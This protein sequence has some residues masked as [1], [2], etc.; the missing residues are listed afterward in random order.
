VKVHLLDGTYELFRAYYGGPPARNEAGVE[1]G[2]A[3]TLLRS[4]ATL[5]DDPGVTHVACAFD[6]VIESF[7]NDLFDGYKTGDGIEPELFAQFELAERV[8]EALGIV[9]WPM[10][11]FEADDAIAAAAE[12]S[13]QDPRVEQILLCSPD[14][15][16]AQCVRGDR[17]VCLDRMRKT[18]MN[19]AG[20][21]AKF[22]VGPGS[23]PDYLALV[24]DTADGIPGI[25]GWGAKSAGTVLA[26]Y[27]S[28]DA[29]PEDVT[30]WTVKVRG[31]EKLARTLNESREAARL[32]KRLATLRSDVPLGITVD[33]LGWKGAQESRLHALCQEL[34]D[35][36]LV[37][38]VT[39]TIGERRQGL[40]PAEERSL[41]SEEKPDA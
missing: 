29:I 18:T 21:V 38:R 4:F 20:V 24:G 27:G 16:L 19:E 41:R 8:T 17:V 25:D 6:H 30:A 12:V 3:R 1:V 35:E 36:R 23:I 5:L 31:A 22:G 15:D 14:K 9:T 7:R 26:A 11:E 32:Y 34:G 39:V 13:F 33:T 28:I 40:A 37:Q 2:A 10:I